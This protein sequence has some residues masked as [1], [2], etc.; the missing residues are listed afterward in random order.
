MTLLQTKKH[1]P[2]RRT[3]PLELRFLILTVGITICLLIGGLETILV[4][5]TT[6]PGT[7]KGY[8]YTIGPTY[9]LDFTADAADGWIQ[10]TSRTYT[11]AQEAPKG[12]VSDINTNII[13]GQ[14]STYSV[15]RGYL[16]F[17]TS[18]IPDTANITTA[19]LRLYGASDS[20]TKDF[21]LLVYSG[22][23]TYPTK[24]L[25]PTDFQANKYT[26]NVTKTIFNTT[27]FSTTG[28]N[29]ISLMTTAINK[30]GFTKLIIWSS[31]DANIMQPQAGVTEVVT[32]YA[33]EKGSD[34]QPQLV[35]VYH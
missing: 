21:L 10:N 35:V 31:R 1:Q 29:N 33:N 13:I 12:T 16:F 5:S 8:A 30:T 7:T 14:N 15:E 34:Y 9:T 22:Q 19:T 26:T 4:L 11:T 24:P 6:F 28:Y 2:R 32:V 20:S 25:Q 17:N 18:L 3:G 27:S 23:P